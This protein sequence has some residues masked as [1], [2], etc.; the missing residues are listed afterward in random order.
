MFGLGLALCLVPKLL[1]LFFFLS[2]FFFFFWGGGLVL[3]LVPR[4]SLLLEAWFPRLC[5]GVGFAFVFVH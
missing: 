1:L 4:F 2:S 3:C 5:S